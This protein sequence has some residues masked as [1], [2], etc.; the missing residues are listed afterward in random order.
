MFVL[1]LF[2]SLSGER[3]SIGFTTICLLPFLFFIASPLEAVLKLKKNTY[4][5]TGIFTHQTFSEK[6]IL[7]FV[8]IQ[9]KNYSPQI[10][11]FLNYIHIYVT[12][13]Q[14]LNKLKTYLDYFSI[15]HRHLKLHTFYLFRVLIKCVFFSKKL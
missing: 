15:I 2:Q 1:L 13:F 11:E 10:F 3:K 8:V 6:S 9:K 4:D 5:R 12:F 14:T 7:F